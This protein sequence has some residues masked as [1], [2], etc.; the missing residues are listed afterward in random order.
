KGVFH[1]SW[2]P[3]LQY[4]LFAAV[5][6]LLDIE[7][8]TMLGLQRM[9]SDQA[10]RAWVVKQVSDPILRAFWLDEFEQ[11]GERFMRE[12]VAPI[13]NKVGQLLLAP[14]IRLIL[15][16]VRS[17]IDMAFM[18]D[19]RRIFIANLAKGR[20]GED[21]SNL[22]GAMLVHQ[23]QLAA[24]ARVDVPEESRRPFHLYI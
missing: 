22:L 13:Q 4:I 14:P 20:I 17:K 11:Y 10:Y 6:S 15:G 3:R 16:Q 19:R 5:A 23:F 18:M 9:L 2:G 21:K 24:M 7:N 8:G 12:A 1:D